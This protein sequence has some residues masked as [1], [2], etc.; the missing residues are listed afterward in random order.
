MPTLRRGVPRP[1]RPMR[2]VAV[3]LLVLTAACGG[4]DPAPRS[5][6]SQLAARC[7]TP[8][9]GVDPQTRARYADVPG[10]VADEKA[11]L[12]AWTDELYLWY[13]EVPTL[14]PTAYPTPVTYFDALKTVALTASGRPKDRFHFTYPTDRWEALS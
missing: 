5:P 1:S 11:W 7:A 10:T 13:R 8:R 2:R 3:A 14:D 4:G 9:T 12:R 6:A